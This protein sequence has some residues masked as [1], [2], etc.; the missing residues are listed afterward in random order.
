MLQQ[1]CKQKVEE[2]LPADELCPEPQVSC[3]GQT[4]RPYFEQGTDLETDLDG[5]KMCQV[6]ARVA[7]ICSGCQWF[8]GP[9]YLG[10]HQHH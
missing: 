4:V 8:D 1:A 5:V 3:P 2:G 9:L 10:P 6:A 7:S